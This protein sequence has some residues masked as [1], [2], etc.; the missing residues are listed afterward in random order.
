[1][2]LIRRERQLEIEQEALKNEKDSDSKARLE[3]VKQEIANINEKKH[4]LEQKW[5]SEKT[6]I[7]ESR[8]IQSELDTLRIAEEQAE[9]QADL[10]K[11][12]E[13]RYGKIPEKE[14]QLRKTQDKLNSLDSSQR[15]RR[16]E[17][18]EEDIASVISRWTG[19]PVTKL[20]DSESNHL[21]H[22]EK[23][24]GRRV[25]GQT[26]AV[27]AVANAIRRSRAGLAPA[28]RPLGSFMFLGPTG[29]GK[30]ELARALAESLFND[31]HAMV[32]IDMSEYMES[33]AVARLIGS[34]PG[35]VG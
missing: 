18:T 6:L 23:D 13:I 7:A 33:H 27:K 9:R 15:L 22:L 1:D 4:Q 32:R 11:A 17:V 2:R 10:A 14:E 31:D 29:V 21:S 16:E 24:L 26:E 20:I 34:P 5:N 3:E 28:N 8:K 12:A 30:T 19:I 25:I 35:Y